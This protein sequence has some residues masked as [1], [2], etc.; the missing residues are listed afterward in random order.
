MKLMIV[1][2]N[3]QVREGIAYGINWQE[4]GIDAVC[5]CAD[6]LEALQKINVFSPDIVIADICMPNM[7]G[8]ELLEK[9]RALDKSCRYI[10]LSAYSEF[11]Y[12]QQAIRLGADDYILKPVKPRKLIELVMKNVRVL[13]DVRQE[14]HDYYNVYE[15]IFINTL[16]A[17]KKID[18]TNRFKKLL[19]YKYNLILET[20]LLF[21]A[22]LKVER[23]D[24]SDMKVPVPELPSSALDELLD[25]TK[26]LLPLPLDG[27]SFLLLGK[28]DY[29]KLIAHTIFTELRNKIKQLNTSFTDKN[30]AITAGI[31]DTVSISE[32]HC[33]YSQA[34]SA[35][36]MAYYE[37]PGSVL[38]YQEHSTA[39]PEFQETVQKD[40][41]EQITSCILSVN[42]EELS[43]VFDAFE[44]ECRQKQYKPSDIAAFFK[45]LYFYVI[46]HTK[47]EASLE[48]EQSL[49]ASHTH[50]DTLLHTFVKFVLRSLKNNTL[51]PSDSYS[52]IIQNICVYLSDHFKEPLTVESVAE[53]FNRT[54]NYISA[55]FKKEVGKSFTDYLVELRIQKATTLLTYT[56]K[57]ISEIAGEVGFNSYTYFSKTFRKYTGKNAGSFRKP[58]APPLKT[59]LHRPSY[60]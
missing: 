35:L 7:D 48:F 37:V 31:S 42:Q 60:I 15:K 32:I 54:P 56:N 21:A 49:L 52:N 22:V 9:V 1:D 3:L 45:R 47:L 14:N 24:S 29:S 4:Y 13:L 18:S 8:I 19:E 20:N 26:C 58:S 30:I 44:K 10:L 39:M 38:F 28:G 40:Y 41:I 43:H 25:Q 12:A 27:H 5:A 34:V 36:D 6:G 17:G 51:L 57:S 53:K 46:R 55:K 50:F 16:L 59:F 11:E 2:D 23:A 33:A